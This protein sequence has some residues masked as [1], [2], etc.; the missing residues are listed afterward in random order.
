MNDMATASTA[1]PPMGTAPPLGNQDHFA[2]VIGIQ[3]YREFEPL[4]APRTDAARFC[5]WLEKHAEVPVKNIHQV[6][7]K[8]NSTPTNSDILE[9]LDQLGLRTLSRKGSRLYIYYAGHG[10]GPA[11]GEVA[12]VPADGRIGGLNQQ[13]FGMATWI[14][15]LV[16][17]RFFDEIVVFLD[18][19][20][21]A[22]TVTAIGLPYQSLAPAAG[23]INDPKFT[24]FVGCNVNERSFESCGTGEKLNETHFRGLMTQALLEGLKGSPSAVDPLSN[25]VTTE[26][27]ERFLKHRVS[28]LAE[29][30]G[31]KQKAY[32]ML[33]SA[34][35]IMLLQLNRQPEITLDLRVGP[36]TAG[37]PI[38]IRNLRTKEWS[39]LGSGS[40]GTL[41]PRVR[42][43]ANTRHLLTDGDELTEVLDPTE[44]GETYEHTLP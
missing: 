17:A 28:A 18:C 19:C 41:L 44:M 8:G 14:N 39:D 29:R 27:L 23:A 4:E 26:S 3:D 24:I 43:A 1:A 38:R 9:A 30:D 25:A 42:L 40:E 10:V 20:R 21:E 36:T 6:V 34:D 37:K 16:Q 7:G 13:V 15:Q 31:L 35:P 5:E 11:V 32:V 22:Q 12:L 33:R 2:L